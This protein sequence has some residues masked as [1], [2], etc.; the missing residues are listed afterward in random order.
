MLSLTSNHSLSHKDP[1]FPSSLFLT[2]SLQPC[3]GVSALQKS[4]RVDLLWHPVPSGLSPLRRYRHQRMTAC[5]Q[6]RMDLEGLR[7]NNGRLHSTGHLISPI[8]LSIC[9]LRSAQKREGFEQQEC[10]EGTQGLSV[11]SAVSSVIH[12]QQFSHLIAANQH[13]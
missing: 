3:G 6:P 5:E 9:F 12:R 1:L 11:P 7:I 10:E 4:V 2:S 8:S 13:N